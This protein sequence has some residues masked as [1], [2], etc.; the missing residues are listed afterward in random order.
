M[1]EM[2][3]CFFITTQLNCFTNFLFFIY[4]TSLEQL[5]TKADV[6]EIVGVHFL[7][8]AEIRDVCTRRLLLS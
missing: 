6:D 3:E 2:P 8:H 1:T 7:M 5:C 4:L